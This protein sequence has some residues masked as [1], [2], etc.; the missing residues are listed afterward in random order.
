MSGLVMSSRHLLVCIN[1]VKGVR[2]GRGRGRQ[3]RQGE[4][5]RMG[6]KQLHLLRISSRSDRAVSPS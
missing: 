5:D 3:L 4:E 2:L 1:Q 6:V